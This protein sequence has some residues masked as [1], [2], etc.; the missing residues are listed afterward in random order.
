MRSIISSCAIPRPDAADSHPIQPNLTNGCF[1]TLP[2]IGES[3]QGRTLLYVG[4]VAWPASAIGIKP[5][6]YLFM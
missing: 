3:Y 4:L 5:L 6:P 1:D 2:Q